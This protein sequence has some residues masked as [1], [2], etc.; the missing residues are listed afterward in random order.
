MGLYRQPMYQKAMQGANAKASMRGNRAKT[1]ALQS[2]LAE[3][4]FARKLAFSGLGLQKK[5]ADLS[6]AGRVETQRV[7]GDRLKERKK[8]LPWQIGIGAGTG[9]MSAL[10]G[11][12]RANLIKANSAKA[13]ARFNQTMLA[14]KENQNLNNTRLGLWNTPGMGLYE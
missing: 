7:A 10:E 12:R 8:Q 9:L 1:S 14:N 3:M 4:D 6:H 13:D 5:R 11:R 2:R